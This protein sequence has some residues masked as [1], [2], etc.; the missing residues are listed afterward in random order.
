MATWIALTSCSSSG[1]TTA[2][3]TP[4]GAAS[5][6]RPDVTVPTDVAFDIDVP[7]SV[8]DVVLPDVPLQDGALGDAD[9][10]AM[11]D[12][13]DSADGQLPADADNLAW[14]GACI[15]VGA[16]VTTVGDFA[17]APTPC[18]AKTC[19]VCPAPFAC[20]CAGDGG[21]PC[22]WLPMAPM[23][24]PRAAAGG[25]VGDDG[26][27]YVFGG[28]KG[29]VQGGNDLADGEIY[30]PAK[31]TWQ[32]M[33]P[34]P[35]YANPGAPIAWGDGKLWVTGANQLA[36]AA[37]WATPADA[38]YAQYDP[39]TNVWTPL[40]TAGSPG[41]CG[42]LDGLYWLNGKLVA[43][44]AVGFAGGSGTNA[45]NPGPPSVY[46]PQGNAWTPLPEMP[47]P[48]AST[49][50]PADSAVVAGNRLVWLQALNFS[51]SVGI[52]LDGSTWTWSTFSPPPCAPKMNIT[53]AAAVGDKIAMWGRHTV[54]IA[55]HE[56]WLWQ[57]TAPMWT[58]IPVPQWVEDYLPRTLI[59]SAGRLIIG[60]AEPANSQ[61]I[62]DL[63]TGKW[64]RVASA[65][66]PAAWHG[67]Q[68]VAVVQNQLL[69][70]GGFFNVPEQWA[71]NLGDR[72]FVPGL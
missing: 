69:L 23:A 64:T 66:G 21:T 72:L 30:D 12:M 67:G 6:V 43:L 40:P 28:T 1:S 17:P 22:A 35:I 33:P 60:G 68:L 39:K 36:G 38:P 54:G 45:A 46:D 27:F 70:V 32:P 53:A 8:N 24:S 57:L 26:R 2:S 20:T 55:S 4:D 11:L 61:A 51:P 10:D 15:P 37:Y 31:D 71:T 44:G 50:T 29:Y 7:D 18:A 3:A 5:E 14:P 41:G 47:T 34:A 9:G 58:P 56:L 59:Y 19:G 52:I 13:A 42:A 65:P 63:N 25:V 48:G 62:L 16:T 49:L